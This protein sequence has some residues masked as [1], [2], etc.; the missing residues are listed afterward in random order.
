MVV[1]LPHVGSLMRV[2]TCSWPSL[3]TSSQHRGWL[4]VG[5]AQEMS[6]APNTSP[7]LLPPWG[8]SVLLDSC[9]V[10]Q[11]GE[12]PSGVGR[13]QPQRASHQVWSSTRPGIRLALRPGR[14]LSTLFTG[15]FS[16]GEMPTG[17]RGA[18]WWVLQGWLTPGV[19]WCQ[20]GAGVTRPWVGSSWAC[21]PVLTWLCDSGPV[22]SP[23]WAS[24][25]TFVKWG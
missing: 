9:L 3:C 1:C 24:V 20:L 14:A 7:F 16:A 12:H 17:Q 11:A 22:T 21:T 23:L 6:N 18:G 8:H 25:A 13:T 10:A 5:R 15:G 19:R 4:S 2:R